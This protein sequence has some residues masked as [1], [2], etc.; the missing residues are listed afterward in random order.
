MSVVLIPNV[1]HYLEYHYFYEHGRKFLN[2]MKAS[3]WNKNVWF[4]F[5]KY[6]IIKC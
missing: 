2:C 1:R 3:W 6:N 5:I 4:K